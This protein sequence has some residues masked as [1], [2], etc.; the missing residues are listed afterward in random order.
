MPDHDGPGSIIARLHGRWSTI[1]TAA[2]PSAAP[3][4]RS[5]P[6]VRYTSSEPSVSVTAMARTTRTAAGLIVA[7][8]AVTTPRERTSER[9][10]RS[11][12]PPAT[13]AHRSDEHTSELQSLI[14]ILYA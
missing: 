10:E 13:G 7:A 8:S 1:A 12:D 5:E 14:H 3:S 11:R 9:S 6:A 2:A 4:I